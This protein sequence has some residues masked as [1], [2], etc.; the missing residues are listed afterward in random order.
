MI[1]LRTGNRGNR[2]QSLISGSYRHIATL[3]SGFRV[4]APTVDADVIHA[5]C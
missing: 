2:Q 5:S 4:T 1:N 3:V